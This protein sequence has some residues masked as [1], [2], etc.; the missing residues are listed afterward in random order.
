[1]TPPDPKANEPNWTPEKVA[2]FNR[3]NLIAELR[4][5]GGDGWDEIDD[6][7]AFL[8]DG[9]QPPPKPNG[10]PPIL[11]LVIADL[12]ER[13]RVGLATYGTPLQP[14]NGRDALEDAYAEAL[15]MCMYLKQ[16]IIERNRLQWGPVAAALDRAV[17]LEGE[18]AK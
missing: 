13:G 3:P 7:E 17:G 2:A 12:Q 16:A 6:P 9:E 11:P 18:G 4:A 5:A 10:H 15:D 8:R 1:M 14:F